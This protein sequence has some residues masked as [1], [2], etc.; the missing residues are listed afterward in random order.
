MK[1]IEPDRE[2]PELTLVAVHPG[3]TVGRV[4]AETRW[5]LRVSPDLE[6]TEPPTGYELE[7][8]RDLKARVMI[9]CR[10]HAATSS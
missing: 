6:E 2:D 3:V 8:L 7:V 4:R 5:P 9:E 1:I 10:S